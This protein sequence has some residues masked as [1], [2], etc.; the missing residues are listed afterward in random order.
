MK[1]AQGVSLS[2]RKL[3]E[4]AR[5]GAKQAAEE[6]NGG[7]FRRRRLDQSLGEA[8]L[9]EESGF[10]SGEKTLPLGGQAEEGSESVWYPE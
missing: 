7:T 9:S 6:R 4:T 5:E 3:V 8:H 1:V 2:Y 10:S